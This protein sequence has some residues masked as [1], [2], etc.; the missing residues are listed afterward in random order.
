MGDQVQPGDYDINYGYSYQICRELEP[1][2]C[3]LPNGGE[4]SITLHVLSP[5]KTPIPSGNPVFGA[6]TGNDEA[7]VTTEESSLEN[8]LTRALEGKSLGA[9]FLV[10]LAGILVSFTPCV[11]PMIPIIIGF[12]GA[13]ADG[14]RSKGFIMSLFFVLGLTIMYAVL[15]VIAGAT[16][17]LLVRSCRMRLFSG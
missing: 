17:A 1:E 13:G 5:E 16:G 7:S 9:F 6:G 8:R 11:Y 4:G 3:F 2:S 14:S 12:V 10:F 15:G